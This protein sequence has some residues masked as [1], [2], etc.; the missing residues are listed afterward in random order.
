FIGLAEVFADCGLSASLIQRKA[1]TADDETSVFALNIGAGVVLAV[2]LSLLSPLV[3][4]FYNQPVLM[5]ML[6]VLS[7]SIVIS[8]FGTV[9]SALLARTM[10]FHKT[11]AIGTA[12]AIVS[13]VTGIVMAFLGW[14]VWS[15]IGSSLSATL[16]GVGLCWTLSPWRPRGRP[17]MRCIRS[18]WD[19]SSKLLYCSLI[20]IAYQNMYSVIIGKVYSPESLGYYN[21]ANRLRMLPA[22]TMT[23]IVN[24][25]AFPLFSRCQDDKP[26]LLRRMREIVRSTLLLSAGGLTLLAVLAD[27]LVPLLLTEKWRP[28]VPLLRILCYAGILYPIHA[29]YLMVL[30]AQGY[31][32]LNARLETIKV[33]MGLVTIALVY[34]YGVTALA[35]AVV[36]LTLIA[37]FLNAWYN[38]KLLGYRWRSQAVDIIPTFVLCAIAGWTAWW[39]AT[40]V[41]GMSLAVLFVQGLSFVLLVG[42]GVFLFRDT[43]FAD[44]WKHLVWAFGRLRHRRAGA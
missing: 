25:V 13:G 20:G 28:S 43:F 42:T 8:S 37:Y 35:W 22:S 38:V 16:V 23:G 6:C 31:S 9:Q 29:L 32:N 33:V 2:L 41:S 18:M 10:Q 11:A 44:P 19:F 1:I 27:P 34:Q 30:Q 40:L 26:L 36:G 14:G 17:R 4:R 3:A 24:R 39:V 5:P 12:R 7:L 21:R 15:L